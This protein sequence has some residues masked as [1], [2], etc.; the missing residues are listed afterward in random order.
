MSSLSMV[1]AAPA[2]RVAAP[3]AR[4]H[5]RGRTATPT[6]ASAAASANHTPRHDVATICSS[7]KSAIREGEA[8]A[9]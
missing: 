3:A 7:E 8:D 1:A 4:A 5:Q 2:A 9:V 6:R